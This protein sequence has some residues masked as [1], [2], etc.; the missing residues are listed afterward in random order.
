VG[1][2]AAVAAQWIDIFIQ[3]LTNPAQDGN[4][5]H[6][7]MTFDVVLLGVVLVEGKDCFGAGFGK[8][9]LLDHVPCD[10]VSVA[11]VLPGFH[12]AFMG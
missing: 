8:A 9:H 3:S 11:T 6:G 7:H 12:D 2:H 10:S 1:L 5:L 4:G